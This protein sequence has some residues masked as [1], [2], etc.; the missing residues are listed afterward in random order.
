MLSSQKIPVQHSPSAKN[1][2]S[3]R[4]PAV[5]TPTERAPL[6]HTPS[7]HQLRANLDRGPLTEGEE[8]SRKGGI[9][10]RRSKSLS[11]FLGGYPG[12]SQ[13]TRRRLGESEDEEEE[14]E[15]TAVESSWASAPEASEA[16]NLALSSQLVVS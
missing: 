8:P 4:S 12:I 15:E 2:S 3:Q 6:D 7:V 11:G 1:K 5:P 14:S 16:Q 10:L 13:G 9:N